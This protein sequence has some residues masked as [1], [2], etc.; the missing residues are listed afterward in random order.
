VDRILFRASG[1]DGQA[2]EDNPVRTLSEHVLSAAAVDPEVVIVDREATEQLIGWVRRAL[3]KMER[4]VLVMYMDGKSYA[5][6]AAELGCSTKA[7]D[8]ALQRIRRKA[9]NHL[10]AAGR[11]S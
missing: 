9:Q 3:S 7:V 2:F 8:N 4:R 6:M 5:K 10:K 1:F 11:W